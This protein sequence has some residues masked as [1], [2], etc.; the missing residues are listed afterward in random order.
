MRCLAIFVV[1]CGCLQAQVQYEAEQ[2]YR[3][4]ALHAFGNLPQLELKATV[5]ISSEGMKPLSRVVSV[6]VNKPDNFYLS[7]KTN[8]NTQTVIVSDGN[9][10][11]ENSYK[12]QKGVRR[13]ELRPDGF[14][15]DG[16]ARDIVP[17]DWPLISARVVGAEDLV[18]EGQT[19]TTKKIEVTFRIQGPETA[20]DHDA[21]LWLDEK[22]GV[23]LK[24]ILQPMGPR[25]LRTDVVVTRFRTEGAMPMDVF[26]SKP[27]KDSVDNSA[28][29]GIA[30]ATGGKPDI[31]F[32]T[33][34]GQPFTGIDF[35]GK[36]AILVFGRP[37]CKPCADETAE[38][39][40]APKKLKANTAGAVQVVV[41]AP[42]TSSG[43]EETIFASAEQMERFGI[44][45]LP[46]TLAI[47]QDGALA[48]IEEGF[49]TADEMI[50]VAE[51]AR[52]LPP[53]SRTLETAFVLSTQPGVIA[54]MPLYKAPVDVASWAVAGKIPGEV[55]ASVVVAPDGSVMM[56]NVLKSSNPV[57]NDSAVE[58]LRKWIFKPGNRDDQPANVAVTILV[59][60]GSK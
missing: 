36:P 18:I 42:S 41:G 49:I 27:A 33:S 45:I 32:A 19:F 55:V 44:Q 58:T 29:F 51:K 34:S 26:N 47:T 16:E 8:N 10:R 28:V 60:F 17:R 35:A 7:T 13:A 25:G 40:V 23:P 12:H 59:R 24:Q 22:S 43:G 6:V 56:V 39:E 14:P 11:V 9:L 57:L 2:L 31:H 30:V 38:F 48:K 15:I 20:T 1:F 53:L 4:A 5:R 54:P 46:A 37:G 52:I 21:T 50:A 3:N